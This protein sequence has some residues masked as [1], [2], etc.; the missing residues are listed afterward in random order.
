MAISRLAAPVSTWGIPVRSTITCVARVA[1]I[2]V[3][4][5]S[6]SRR[7][8]ASL[9]WPTIGTSSSR[10][11]SCRI[12]VAISSIRPSWASTWLVMSRAIAAAPMM[13][14]EPSRIGDTLSDTG[15][16]RPSLC[17]RSV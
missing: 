10:S 9:T 2:R 16:I 11:R 12:G 3:S 7:V 5:M 8:R 15:T 17:W 14:P 13:V 4:S 1:G 6:V